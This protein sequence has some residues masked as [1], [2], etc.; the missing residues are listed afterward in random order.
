MNEMRKPAQPIPHPSIS[1]LRVN[2]VL[3]YTIPDLVIRPSPYD[4]GI[5]IDVGLEKIV[6]QCP[7]CG[8]GDYVP[9]RVHS[10][11]E[12]EERGWLIRVEELAEETGDQ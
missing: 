7:H 4:G 11:E 6:N 12:A 3:Y 1:P 2:D 9:D 5:E 8:R 10:F